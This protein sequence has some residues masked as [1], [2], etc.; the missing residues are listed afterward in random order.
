[1]I[2]ATDGVEALAKA[3]ECRPDVIVTDGVM[4]GMDG[5]ALTRQLKDDAS[6]RTIPVIMLTAEDPGGPHG[7]G[8]A[9][10]ALVA[11][12]PNLARLLEEVSRALGGS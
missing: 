11:K 2:K 9:P 12:S 1:V 5:F 10:D 6:T 3:R 8:P 7:Q 4:P